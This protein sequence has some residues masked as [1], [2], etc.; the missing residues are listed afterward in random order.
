MVTLTNFEKLSLDLEPLCDLVAPEDLDQIIM[1]M[2]PHMSILEYQTPER[3][4]TQ[5]DSLEEEGT[6][7]IH[8]SILAHELKVAQLFEILEAF[9][10]SHLELCGLFDLSAYGQLDDGVLHTFENTDDDP[11]VVFRAIDSEMK[12][13]LRYTWV[14]EDRVLL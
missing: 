6:C 3:S 4:C 2:R 10:P 5:L 9:N 1:V 14:L 12:Y 8:Q 7:V 13:G 11:T